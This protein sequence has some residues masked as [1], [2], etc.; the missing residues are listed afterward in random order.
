MDSGNRT[1]TEGSGVRSRFWQ[2]FWRRLARDTALPLRR[3]QHALSE[4]CDLW[5]E[6]LTVFRRSVNHSPE[7]FFV[8]TV[9][10]VGLGLSVMMFLALTADH[11]HWLGTVG[12]GRRIA[13]LREHWALVDARFAPKLDTRLIWSGRQEPEQYLVEVEPLNRYEITSR[14]QSEPIPVAAATEPA[15]PSIVADEW[16]FPDLPPARSAV[17]PTVTVSPAI[18]PEF[19]WEIE[20]QRQPLAPRIVPDEPPTL[21][22]A[23]SVFPSQL[24]QER[25][26]DAIT[27]GTG[28][29]SR[30]LGQP[31]SSGGVVPV[32]YIDRQD[33]PGPTDSRR[34]DAQVEAADQVRDLSI[35]SAV[36]VGLDLTLLGPVHGLAHLVQKSYLKIVNQGS[37]SLPRLEI[38]E[39][40]ELLQTVIDARPLAQVENGSLKR[41]ILGLNSGSERQLSVDWVPRESGRYR[42]EVIVRAEALVAAQ[43]EVSRAPVQ[44]QPLLVIAARRLSPAV[45]V[46][47][48]LEVE[49]EV[50]NDGDADARDVSI[51]ADVSRALLHRY[52]SELEY[53]VG[54][55][56]VG[57]VHRT[58]LRMSGREAGDGLISLQATAVAAVPAATRVKALVRPKPSATGQSVT[59]TAAKPILPT[60]AESA[61]PG[62]RMAITPAVS[63]SESAEADRPSPLCEPVRDLSRC[64]RPVV[65][66][67]SV[68]A[69]HAPAE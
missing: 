4:A 47:E 3:A 54:D 69:T 32:A 41:S 53:R 19:T 21:T 59:T 52:G 40:L 63:R 64:W 9:G 46:D 6:N 11:F 22:T 30:G 18:A 27:G 37:D 39:P 35:P 26:R 49:I 68:A 50:R 56:P 29:W 24:R 34:P 62:E 57:G 25:F 45:Q 12:G 15:Q 7:W 38:L 2:L 31:S 10:I 17:S 28:G 1:A 55:I 67:D 61:R 23:K 20:F 65:R 66:Q 36:E 60:T 44:G 33:L 48:T 13:K 51:Y 5:F 58:V 42:H 16:A 43:T 8:T 14:A